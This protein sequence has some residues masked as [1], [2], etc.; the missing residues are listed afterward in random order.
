MSL[1]TSDY[2]K[3]VKSASA[4][5]E[6][7]ADD[8]DKLSG[9]AQKAGNGFTVAKGVL[10]NFISG[11]VTAAVSAVGN[12]A[13]TIWNLDEATA[14]HSIAMGR[15]NTAYEAAGYGADT[16]Q[17][18]FT[19]FYGIL[20]DT[21]TATEASQLL[22]KLADSAEDV[23]TWTD[24]AAG[25][26][27]TFGDSLPIESLIE[28]ANETARV[29]EVTG[30]LADALN[31][32]GEVGEDEFNAMLAECSSEA[33]RNQLIMDTLAG[34]YGEAADAFY[35]NNEALVAGRESQVQMQDSLSQLGE[36]I[37]K[38]KTAFSRF[39]FFLQ[40]RR[41]TITTSFWTAI[42]PLFTHISIHFTGTATEFIWDT[43]IG[44]CNNS[45]CGRLR[46]NFFNRCNINKRILNRATVI[47]CQPQDIFVIRLLL[48]LVLVERCSIISLELVLLILIQ[49]ILTCI[50]YRLVIQRLAIRQHS[51]V[52]ITRL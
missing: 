33:E 14:E 10:A 2:E 44:T 15:L 20:G 9:A 45:F 27:G 50:I 38:I 26:S 16:A 12:L 34:T 41:E 39:L 6:K 49:R 43:T 18:A 31:W 11:G 3:G 28:A 46:D 13:S 1:D 52:I 47:I 48:L 42:E 40:Q 24:I 4:S 29:G 8:L 23:S 30:T 51:S 22:A 25:V 21:D 7:L 17:Q 19:A 36:A 35:K 37:G 5:G 32:A